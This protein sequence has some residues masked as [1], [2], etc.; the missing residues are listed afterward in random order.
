M[1]DL[2]GFGRALTDP[3]RVRILNALLQS[4]LCVCELVDALQ[5][6]QSTISTHLQI[7]RAAGVVVTEKRRK[8]VIYS[9]ERGAARAI[10]AAFQEFPPDPVQ[11]EQDN[12]RLAYRIRLRIDGCCVLSSAELKEEA[13]SY[14]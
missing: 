11:V 6:S 5:V 1:T 3:T 4:E 12:R 7:L 10:L 13:T 2:L 9:I 14:V 8:W